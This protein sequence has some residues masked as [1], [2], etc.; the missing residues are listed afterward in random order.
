MTII[1]RSIGV[2]FQFF[3]RNCSFRVK[4]NVKKTVLF[5]VGCQNDIFCFLNFILPWHADK[6]R[7]MFKEQLFRDQ[8]VLVTGGGSGIGFAIAEKYLSYGA[9]VYIASRK[10]ERLEAALTKL[11]P[12]GPCRAF[13]LD[14]REPE[15]IEEL[16]ALIKKESG[17]L[18]ILVNNAGG[19]FP[20]PAQEISPNGWR[21]VINTNLN[22]TWFM[23]QS[24][25]K[26][27]FLPQAV[28]AIVN[29]VVNNLRGFP[30]MAHSGA[31]RAGVEN[32]SK[33]LA[34]EWVRKNIRVNCV[35]PGVIKS[36]G[37][38]NYPPELVEQVSKSIPMRRLGTV[39]EV[40]DLVL[41]LSSPATTY[42]TGETVYIDG[43]AR[44]WGEM[45]QIE[46]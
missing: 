22:G 36:T 42:I 26:H 19:Q 6:I 16:A 9:E 4:L 34:I 27:F 8:T 30:G 5:K 14:I 38:E 43:G 39:E 21:A 20:A 37:L 32:L 28:G 33:S 25:A 45:W 44:L 41:Y 18:D 40:A 29:I 7:S 23:T 1:P 24:M 12:Q 2:P 17:K 11:S 15:A 13:P 10:K 35:A 31:A 46:D 3:R